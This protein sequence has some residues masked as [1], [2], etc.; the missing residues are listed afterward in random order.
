L[1]KFQ[2]KEQEKEKEEEEGKEMRYFF[3]IMC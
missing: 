2:G 3:V 1:E